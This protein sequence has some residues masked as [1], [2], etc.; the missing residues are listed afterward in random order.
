MAFGRIV[1]VQQP[2][3]VAAQQQRKLTA[4]QTEANQ[5]NAVPL[6]IPCSPL[7]PSG[8]CDQTESKRRD[9]EVDIQ[10][11]LL[12]WTRMV[13]IL[14]IIVGFAQAII[15]YIQTQH[16][17]KAATAAATN[18]AAVMVSERAWI[19]L[20]TLGLEDFEEG[21]RFGPPDDRMWVPRCLIGLKNSGNSPAFIQ[22]AKVGIFISDGAEMNLPDV[23]PYDS[24]VDAVAPPSILVAGE[25]TNWR[26]T[27]R[28]HIS[29][30]HYT[31]ILEARRWLWVFGRIEYKDAFD[32]SHVYGFARQ[33]DPSLDDLLKKRGARWRHV[34]HR[35]Y[36]YAD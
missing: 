6:Q 31:E 16:T 33:Y 2:S 27:P 4:Q 1:Y 20:E 24:L 17:G 7:L 34:H 9:Q 21:D 18:S 30:E 14:G 36:S 35:A 10:G 5:S 11:K 29:L 32:K 19:S 15:I 13:A 23:P 8:E 22:R 25:T 26:Q 3:L 28:V 12:Y